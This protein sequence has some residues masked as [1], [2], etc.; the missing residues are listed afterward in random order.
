MNVTAALPL[1][2]FEYGFAATLAV[3]VLQENVSFIRWSGIA[4]VSRGGGP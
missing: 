3:M 2:A 4:L 1:T